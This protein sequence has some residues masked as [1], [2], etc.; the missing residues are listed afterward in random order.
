MLLVSQ[1]P[2]P[3]T[4]T[5]YYI[6]GVDEAGRGPCAGPVVAAALILPNGV[7]KYSWAEQIKDSKK[8]TAQ[9]RDYLF[10]HLTEH[11]VSAVAECSVEEID[12]L[13]ILWATML[14][15]KRAVES[16][17]TAPQKILVDGNRLPDVKIAGEAVVGGDDK[18]LCIAAASIIAKV[19]R[20]RIMQKLAVEFPHYGWGD[21]SG[22]ATKTHLTA[23]DRYGITTHHRKSYAPVAKTLEKHQKMAA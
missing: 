1:N 10:S 3:N 13:N 5:P 2:S 4:L 19:T 9:K 16:L 7:E 8:L 12:Q 23:M 18:Y 17:A 15:M 14:A 11:C 21:N 6:A 20:D 22:Y